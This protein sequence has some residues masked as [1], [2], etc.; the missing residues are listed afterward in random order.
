VP[1]IASQFFKC[2]VKTSDR[3]LSTE[4]IFTLLKGIVNGSE[5]S[6]N[7]IPLGLLTSQNRLIW[8]DERIKLLAGWLC[9]IPKSV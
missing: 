6:E 7:E 1:F 5:L 2:P 8:A 3:R 9:L 4:E